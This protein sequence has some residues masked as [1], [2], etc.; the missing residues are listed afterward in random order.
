M[1]GRYQILQ[2]GPNLSARHYFLE[3]NSKLQ[4]YL[5][6]CNLWTHALELRQQTVV[7]ET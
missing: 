4:F 7:L 3:E 2:I 5:Q 1:Y 6:V